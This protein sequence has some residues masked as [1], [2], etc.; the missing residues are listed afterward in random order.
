MFYA[1]LDWETFPNFLSLSPICLFRLAEDAIAHAD[2][3]AL[4]NS[5]SLSSVDEWACNINFGL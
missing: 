4:L 3:H 5:T 2:D 1:D